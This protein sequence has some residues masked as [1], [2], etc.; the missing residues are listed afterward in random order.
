MAQKK[1]SKIIFCQY[2]HSMVDEVAEYNPKFFDK[3]KN[4]IYL[5]D[6]Q[7]V[8]E[9]RETENEFW[10][11]NARIGGKTQIITAS[12]QGHYPAN[13][14]N[15]VAKL[16]AYLGSIDPEPLLSKIEL[17]EEIYVNQR[18]DHIKDIDKTIAELDKAYEGLAIIIQHTWKGG[19]YL[20]ITSTFITAKKMEEIAKPIIHKI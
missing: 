9:G 7:I 18:V 17:R 19:K 10:F 6:R 5:H 1:P 11:L 14:E 4:A 12:Q 8:A 13:D 3:A 20:R 2:K 15:I 16:A